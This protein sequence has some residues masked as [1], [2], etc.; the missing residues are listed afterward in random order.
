MHMVRELLGCP[1]RGAGANDGQVAQNQ[2]GGKNCCSV[3]RCAAFVGAF[4]V[5][6]LAGGGGGF[7]VGVTRNADAVC[8]R[9]VSSFKC[10]PLPGADER[11]VV[12]DDGEPVSCVP[13]PVSLVEGST[14]TTSHP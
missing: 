7:Y 5:A 10:T 2:M 1:R 13:M 6:F 3:R 11:G 14:S 8:P 9:P 12:F 4:S